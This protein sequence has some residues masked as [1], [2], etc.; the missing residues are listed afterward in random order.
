M[1]DVEDLVTIGQIV[2]PFGI[3]GDAK[4]RSLSDVPGRFEGLHDVTLVSP[5][6]RQLSTV[7]TRVRGTGVSY[8]VGFEAFSNPE[9]VTAF[10]GGWVMIPR[11]ESPALPPGH[12]FESDLIGLRV[13]CEDGTLVGVLEDIWNTGGQHIFA[14][15]G[16]RGEVLLPAAKE[17]VISV[18]IAGHTMTVRNLEG[19]LSEEAEGAGCDVT[20]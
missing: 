15:R 3:R 10:R 1:G 9:E 16:E 14:V 11:S 5:T 20:S 12:Y 7:V 6:G 17:M 2:K 4:V 19:L 8:V 18:N 13:V